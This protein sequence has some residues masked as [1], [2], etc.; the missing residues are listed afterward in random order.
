MYFRCPGN[1]EYAG[2][3]AHRYG[4]SPANQRNESWW[5]YPRKHLTNWWMN[6]FKDMIDRETLNTANRLHMECLWF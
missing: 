4:C 3:K 6:Y 1:D 2:V 5:S